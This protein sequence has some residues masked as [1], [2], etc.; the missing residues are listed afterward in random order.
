MERE[1]FGIEMVEISVGDVVVYAKS[2][3]ELISR[4]RRV[5]ERLRERILIKAK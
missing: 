3:Q 5:F 1:L 2:M 4:L